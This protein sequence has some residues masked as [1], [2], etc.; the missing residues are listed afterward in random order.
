MMEAN[1]VQLIISLR[2]E[3]AGIHY[4]RYFEDNENNRI[5]HFLQK[6]HDSG[7][8]L[9]GEEKTLYEIL[10]STFAL[11]YFNASFSGEDLTNIN[12]QDLSQIETW[13]V[14]DYKNYISESFRKNDL[15]KESLK[16]ISIEKYS[17]LFRGYEEDIA[18]YRTLQ[19]WH[20]M[21]KINFLLDGGFFT[22]NELKENEN[23]ILAIYDVLINENEGNS[24]LYFMREK[25]LYLCS[26]DK[27]LNKL[28]QLQTILKSDIDGDY[29]V[30]MM[31]DIMTI[32]RNDD[33]SREAL[34][35]ADQAKKQFPSSPFLKEIQYKEDL[36]TC[37]ELGLNFEKQIQSNKPIH[38]VAEYRNTSDFILNIY[39]VKGGFKSFIKYTEDY[40]SEEKFYHEI[41]KILIRKEHYT[42]PHCEIYEE[43]KTSL[44]IKPLPPGLYVA[45]FSSKD[46]AESNS[47]KNYF[48]TVSDYKIIYHHKDANDFPE[49]FRLVNSENGTPI[50]NEEIV[51]FEYLRDQDLVKLNSKTDALGIFKI[52]SDANNSYRKY[53]VHQPK[54]NDFQILDVWGRKFSEEQ[55]RNIL[56]KTIPQIFTDRA[57]YRPGQTVYFKVINTKIENE[58]EL[59]VAGL[60]Q[61]IALTDG[62]EEEISTQ[63]FTTNEFGSY[64][65][66][67]V[68]P[69]GKLN[70]TFAL[71]IEDGADC[72]HT[73]RVEEYKRPKFEITFEPV[74]GEYQYGQ[75]L[76]LKGRATSFSGVPLRDVA[77][78]YEIIKRNI[79][80]KFFSHYSNDYN[81]ENSILGNAETDENG[82]F[83]ISVTFEENTYLKGLQVD[84]F[85]IEASVT[86]I[87]GETQSASVEIN[88][89]SVPYYIKAEEIKDAF[90]DENIKI[91]VETK[92]YNNQ[93]VEKPY[94]V[95]LSKLKS[96][97]R[98]FRKMFEDKIQNLSQFSKEEFIAK[99][100]H[101]YF[102]EDEYEEEVQIEKVIL[103]KIYDPKTDNQNP[104]TDNQQLT[105]QSHPELVE[106]NLDLGKLEVGR[107]ELELYDSQNKE[108]IE[109]SQYFN[110]WD[111]NSL[112]EEK[113]F[114]NVVDPKKGFLRGEKAN[115][116]VYSA[117]PDAL[118]YIFLQDCLGNTTVEIKQLKNGVLN[119]IVEIPKN[120]NISE[121]N[122]QFQIIAYN[123]VQHSE[124]TVKIKENENPLI[125][126][127]TTFR[128]KIE[129]GSKEKW[130]VK[131]TE[132]NKN[133]STLLSLTA[134]ILA[135][136]YD[137]S[138]DQFSINTFE[139]KKHYV[140]YYAVLSYKVKYNLSARFAS[141]EVPYV[142]SFSIEPP[143]FNWYDGNIP[144]GLT[145]VGGSSGYSGDAVL[146]EFERPKLHYKIAKGDEKE[147]GISVGE[148]HS[149]LPQVPVR[150]NLNETA[151]FYPDLRTDSEGNVSFEFTSPEALTK[152][153][154]MFFAH[155][156]DAKS[157]TLEKEVVTQKEFSV[158]PNY[159]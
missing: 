1:V 127:T 38:I 12:S 159:P 50:P 144:E 157:G 119:Y 128:D 126:E 55:K 57:I 61:K 83:T 34:E 14:L 114:L 49:S 78:N 51:F 99:F 84:C 82:E 72:F 28:Q 138:L 136:M 48:F 139:W 101:D 132:N 54:T 135:T 64:H 22:K 68:L 109:T 156:K 41:E 52:P 92:N 123:E 91:N 90:T 26:L 102:D 97:D 9:Q 140:P 85:K 125:I 87:N 58:K 154:L 120:K 117:I 35:I 39:E 112:K 40:R 44:E 69:K 31:R 11:D 149:D 43:M 59:V 27:E 16:K 79:R 143:C 56:N 33:K 137:R 106:G 29:K 63:E 158:T 62:N 4:A 24:K 60:K 122:V 21:R 113:V 7:K 118:V 150:Q 130:T 96:P 65:G 93:D 8:S 86:D 36:M 148:T 147:R 107:Y 13:T 46:L 153:K 23:K 129:P 103:D 141:K 74:K 110:V 18:Y 67:F 105:T 66:S 25:L 73:F 77:V 94:H 134:E 2:N 98:I 32:Y 152:W 115:I 104:S 3:F 111:K 20:L 80:W 146:N 19:D 6:V 121:I 76:E 71:I 81:H 89:A 133:A 70:G 75:T 47:V 45:E 151:F 17:P 131:I 15:R 155:T 37:P 108:L 42:L 100:P 5:S 88:V 124:I 30:L 95:K 142:R 116:Y 53:L 10:V 145:F